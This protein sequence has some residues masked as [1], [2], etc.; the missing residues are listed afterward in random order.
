MLFPVILFGRY[1]E[2]NGRIKIPLNIA[3][4]HAVADG[5]HTCLFLN[6]VGELAGAFQLPVEGASPPPG[7]AARGHNDHK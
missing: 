6:R 4:N 1:Y 5:Y 3:V 7:G 2:E